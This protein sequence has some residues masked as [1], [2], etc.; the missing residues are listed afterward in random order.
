MFLL[1]PS[2]SPSLSLD[3]SAQ[4]LSVCLPV[5]LSV[6]L[7]LWLAGCLAVCPSVSVWLSVNASAHGLCCVDVCEMVKGSLRAPESGPLR[8]P[9]HL[10]HWGWDM[11]WVQ[12][13]GLH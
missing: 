2:V 3:P 11:G 6:C 13:G 8:A 10:E 12:H 4:C 5:C 9:D 7:S 1:G